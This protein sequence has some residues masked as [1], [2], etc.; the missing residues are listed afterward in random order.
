MS[1]AE[2]EVLMNLLLDLRAACPIILLAGDGSFRWVNGNYCSPYDVLK[3]IH[4]ANAVIDRLG[5][6]VEAIDLD[7]AKAGKG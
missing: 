4:D 2:R 7:D 1:K 5:I 3:G 6:A